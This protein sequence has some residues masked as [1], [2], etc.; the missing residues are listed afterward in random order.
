MINFAPIYRPAGSGISVFL[1]EFMSFYGFLSSLSCPTL[2]CG[3]F[4]I[5]LDTD[6]S[7]S[8][9]FKSMLDS[10]NLVQQMDCPTRIHRHTVDCFITPSDFTGI[11]N[12]SNIGCISD[13][14]CVG[15]K[16]DFRSP[17]KYTTKQITFRQYHRIYRAQMIC[18]LLKTAF[19][20]SPSDDASDLYT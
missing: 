19:V 11:D 2:I 16:L 7:S 17:S 20:S 8:L 6:T 12:V 18:D 4:N 9:N 15:C 3:D 10:C 1:G 13:H 5:H 14:F